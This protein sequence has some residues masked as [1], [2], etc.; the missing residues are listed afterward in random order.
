MG[1]APALK[2]SFG[3][4]SS[5]NPGAPFGGAPLPE[6]QGLSLLFFDAIISFT[7]EIRLI[8]CDNIPREGDV[9][10]AF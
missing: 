9:S 8:L 6:I 2:L 4:D 1:V 7:I 5:H 10:N 3:L